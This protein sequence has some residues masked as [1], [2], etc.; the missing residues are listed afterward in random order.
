MIQYCEF[1]VKVFIS[2]AMAV[3]EILRVLNLCMWQELDGFGWD[4]GEG[5]RSGGEGPRNGEVGLG[6]DGRG[7]ELKLDLKL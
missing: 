3:T 7:G 5:G 1:R 4:V 6:G 2:L